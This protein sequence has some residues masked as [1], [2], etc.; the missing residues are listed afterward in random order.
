MVR[1]EVKQVREE[2]LGCYLFIYLGCTGFSCGMQTLSCGMHVESSSPTR[3][4][5]WVPCIGSSE[6]YPLDHQGSLGLG[7]FD[8]EA[9]GSST[10]F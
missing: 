3:D 4:R 1:T 8:C 2:G 5:T 9:I 10:G 7:S 6:S